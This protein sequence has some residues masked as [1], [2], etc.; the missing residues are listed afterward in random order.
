MKYEQ[1]HWFICVD[2]EMVNILLGEQTFFFCQVREW[3]SRE[4]QE[5]GVKNVI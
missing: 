5:P 2:F 3:S 4:G 1:H